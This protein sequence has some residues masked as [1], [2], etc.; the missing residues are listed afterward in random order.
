MLKRGGAEF[1]APP[2]FPII[3][4][5]PQPQEHFWGGQFSAPQPHDFVSFFPQSQEF[6]SHLSAVQFSPHLQTFSQLHEFFAQ[7][8]GVQSSPHVHVFSTFLP[9]LHEFSAHFSAVQSS[10]HLQDFSHS[11]DFSAQVSAVQFSPQT[12]VLGFSFIT[13]FSVS[14]AIAA[15]IKPNNSIVNINIF[16]IESHPI[17]YFKYNSNIGLGNIISIPLQ[18]QAISHEKFHNRN[19]F[20]QHNPN[21]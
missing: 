12:Q 10:P 5:L 16:F 20:L 6:F 8:S 7:F 13:A 15:P 4:Y 18:S 1:S 3:F 17:F 2:L 19:C 14:E 11:H 21:Q 9:Q